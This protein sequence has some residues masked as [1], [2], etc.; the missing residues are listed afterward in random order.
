MKALDYWEDLEKSV[1]ALIVA[2][3]RYHWKATKPQPV[4]EL[5]AKL[6]D[7]RQG[8]IEKIHII[9]RSLGIDIAG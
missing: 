5:R 3:D 6:C 4:A 7:E 8:Y 2:I 9:K 1:M